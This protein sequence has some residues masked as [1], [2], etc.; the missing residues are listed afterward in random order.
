[1]MISYD[2]QTYEKQAYEQPMGEQPVFDKA[3]ASPGHQTPQPDYNQRFHPQLP[4]VETIWELNPLMF[5]QRTLA[6]EFEKKVGLITSLGLDL[7]FAQNEIVNNSTA[8]VSVNDFGLLPKIRFYPAEELSG[9]FF[10][11]KVFLGQYTNSIVVAGETRTL[12]QW[13][14]A[15]MAHLGY[16]I[17]SFS[18]L[19]MAAYVGAGTNIPTPTFSSGDLQTE[20]ASSNGSS[21]DYGWAKL[22]DV[23]TG[24]RAD[25]GLTFG[26][27]Y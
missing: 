12:V 13:V 7:Q 17:T 11:A 19:T 24:F 14:T 6:F 15:P 25:F 26:I 21:W 18:G 27:A 23:V 2:P 4:K 3:P 16:R 1:M 22:N 9:I 10:G 5:I 8:E 20:L